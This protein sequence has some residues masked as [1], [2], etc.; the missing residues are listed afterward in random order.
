MKDANGKLTEM[1]CGSNNDRL[2]FQKLPGNEK[3]TVRA[4][5][6]ILDKFCVGDAAYHEISMIDDQFPRSYL[7]KQ[8]RNDLNL[9]FHIART[10]GKHP[11][12]QMNF[13]DELR[14]QIHKK[15]IFINS[16]RS[17]C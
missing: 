4:L 12:A 7:I 15:V 17:G 6:Y 8:C 14:R 1:E 10:P 11:G 3:D 5:L 16:A 9:I 2:S 13:K